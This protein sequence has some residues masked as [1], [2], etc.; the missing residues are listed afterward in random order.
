MSEPDVLKET[1]SVVAEAFPELW[2]A[3]HLPPTTEMDA[4]LPCIV[5]DVLP[6]ETRQ[7]AWNGDDFPV[8]LDEVALDVE[9]FARSRGQAVPVAQKLRQVLYQLPYI[10]EVSVASVDCPELVTREDLNP[11]V[12]VLGAEAELTKRP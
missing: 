12:K 5:L 7:T 2:V 11:R 9:V 3:D 1:I 4:Q 10:A 8:L 6:G